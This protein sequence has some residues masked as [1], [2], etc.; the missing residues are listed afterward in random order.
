[1]T[2]GRPLPSLHTG[3]SWIS[4]PMPAMSI[5]LCTSEPVVASSIPAAAATM[6]IGARLATNMARICCTP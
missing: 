6:K 1:M 3:N 4:V 5:A 2:I